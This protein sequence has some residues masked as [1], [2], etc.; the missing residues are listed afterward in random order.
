MLIAWVRVPTHVILSCSPVARLCFEGG[1]LHNG[2]DTASERKWGIEDHGKPAG[3]DEQRSGGGRGCR[4]KPAIA[5]RNGM[6]G[7]DG[8]L[9]G[10]VRTERSLLERCQHVRD[11]MGVTKKEGKRTKE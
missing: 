7:D 4:G 2:L 6:V 10:S 5:A 1:G 3:L 8:H 11:C 9:G